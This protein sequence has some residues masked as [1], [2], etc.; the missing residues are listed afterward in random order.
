MYT[1][2]VSPTRTFTLIL[3]ALQAA[4][5]GH[6]DNCHYFILSN[7]FAPIVDLTLKYLAAPEPGEPE[8]SALCGPLLS[9]LASVLS[10]LSSSFPCPALEQPMTDCIR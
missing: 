1:L 4:C 10:T 2:C 3:G 6:T 5:A 8:H 9:L 7:K